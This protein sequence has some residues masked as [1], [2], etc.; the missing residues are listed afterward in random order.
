MFR[1]KSVQGI[2]M[3]ALLIGAL[4]PTAPAAS[5]D[6][7]YE[8]EWRVLVSRANQS[9]VLDDRASEGKEVITWKRHNGYNQQWDFNEVGGSD[10]F[11]VHPRSNTVKC[12]TGATSGK[13]VRLDD[14]GDEPNK[15]WR[16]LNVEEGWFKL[17]N[18]STG[19]CLEYTAPNS[20]VQAGECDD[21]Y[22]EQWRR[23]KP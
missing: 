16:I 8:P 19:R 3:A 9:Q 20:A 4:S 22:E 12:V 1:Y 13:G 2:A 17:R 15:E 14:C 18:R 6:T 11:N 21:S 23:V 5:A 7:K 10:F